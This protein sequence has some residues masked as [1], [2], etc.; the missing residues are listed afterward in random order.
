[1]LKR[2]QNSRG[3]LVF[4]VAAAILASAYLGITFYRKRNCKASKKFVQVKN[5]GFYKNGIKIY[6]FS[7]NYW[8]AMNLGAETGK[9]DR[10]RLLRDLDDLKARGVNNIRIMAGTEGPD[11]QPFRAA[12]SLMFAPGEYNKE[13]F[14]GLDFVLAEAS[15]RNITIVMCLNNYWHWS[16]GFAQYVSWVTGEE[17]P[18]PASWDPVNKNLTNGSFDDFVHFADRFY[19]D[20][21]V[22]YSASKMFKNHI[23]TVINRRN[24]I[25]GTYYKDD[26]TIFGWELANEPQF[27]P[28]SWIEDVAGFIKEL[29]SNHLVTAGL[30]SRFDTMEFMDAHQSPNIDYCTV[31][32][33]A[34][35]RGEYNMTDPS[36]ENIE[37]AIRWGKSWVEKAHEW[38]KALDKPIVLEEFGFPR[39]NFER[40]DVLYSPLNPTTRR[41]EYFKN[42]LEHVCSLGDQFY[43]GFGF[44][45]YS[46]I[47]R[48]GDSWVG[49]PPHEAP[50]WYGLYNTDDSTFQ[51]MR[52]IHNKM[53][54]LSN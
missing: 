6:M 18:Y 37:H 39:D 54:T 40:P 12:P 46:G 49:D 11:N 10:V 1:M 42:L 21:N 50:G 41:D 24:E 44:W 33:W 23:Q 14:K 47:S 31:H 32:I 17:I 29:D 52:E 16:G 20:K 15:K 9:G 27:P 45:S 26:P 53:A 51:I 22:A 8:Q 25:T 30:E 43:A 5:G 19:K 13:I 36:R 2:L 7:A 3:R 4:T 38:A 28:K 48:P 35:N 34:Q